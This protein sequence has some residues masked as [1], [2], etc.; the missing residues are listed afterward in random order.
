MGVNNGRREKEMDCVCGNTDGCSSPMCVG[1]D[2]G[3]CEEHT[4]GT[5]DMVAKKVREI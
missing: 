5:E 4:T 1:V 3:T 2:G